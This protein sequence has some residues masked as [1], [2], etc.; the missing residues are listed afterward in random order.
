M[1]AKPFGGASRRTRIPNPRGG[2]EQDG[3]SCVAFPHRLSAGGALD[4]RHLEPAGCRA[5]PRP[6][7]TV[8]HAFPSCPRAIRPC[9]SGRGMDQTI[10]DRHGHPAVGFRNWSR[11]HR[12]KHWQASRRSI[13]SDGRQ[14]RFPAGP[15]QPSMCRMPRDFPAGCLRVVSRPWCIRQSVQA[16]LHGSWG[17][18]PSRFPW[19]LPKWAAPAVCHNGQ[20]LLVRVFVPRLNRSQKRPT[21][22]VLAV[23]EYRCGIPVAQIR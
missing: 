21:R 19:R 15:T 5:A 3:R 20:P 2:M 17:V 14:R 9:L 22:L 23:V 6:R 4:C 11:A 7:Q 16:C 8:R 18:E 10:E 12:R 1:R 13:V